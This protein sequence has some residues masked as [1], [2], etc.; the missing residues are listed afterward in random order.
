MHLGHLLIRPRD[1]HMLVA[2]PRDIHP[3]TPL[4]RRQRR[5]PAPRQALHSPQRQ[6][7][8]AHLGVAPL[9]QHRPD[10]HRLAV[11]VLRGSILNRRTEQRCFG[12]LFGLLPPLQHRLKPLAQR[13][14]QRCQRSHTLQ[15]ATQ[16]LRV[17]FGPRLLRT[18]RA[19]LSPRAQYHAQGV[20]KQASFKTRS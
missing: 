19:S 3:P 1:T 4:Q 11:G 9:A 15:M 6:Q 8:L 2:E 20:L 12:D 18:T 14:E 10:F 17:P 5:I 7:V 16:E 13:V